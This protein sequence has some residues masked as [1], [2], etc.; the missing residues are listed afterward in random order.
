MLFLCLILTIKI[1]SSNNDRLV[2]KKTIWIDVG[3]HFGQEYNSIFGSNL[4][5]YSNI[6]KRFVGGA[7]LKRGKFVSKEGLKNILDLRSKLRKRSNEFHSIFIEANPKIVSRASVYLRADEVFNIALVGNSQDPFSIKKLYLGVGDELSQ[8]SSIFAE[9]DAVDKS[10]FI[11][12]MGITCDTFFYQL[13]LHIEELYDDYQILLR[14]N[15]EG[16]ED[17]V[18]YSLYNIFD[19]KLKMICGSLNDFKRLRGE[20]A[21]QKLDE[22]MDEK[23]LKF[24]FFSSHIYSWPQAHNAIMDLLEN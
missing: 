16:T 7:I 9:N 19:N 17:E 24:V 8:G 5:F 13:K 2:M 15:C 20:D 6:I 18:I 12:T 21:A 4:S 11:A 1:N 3:T 10:T 23:K 14:L 22:F